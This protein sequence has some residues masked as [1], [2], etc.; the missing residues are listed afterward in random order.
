M[1]PPAGPP[2]G[3]PPGSPAASSNNAKWIVVG[4]LAAAAVAIAAFL[5]LRSDDKKNSIAATSSSSPSS[6]STSSSSSSSSK[7]SSSSSTSSSSGPTAA[8]LQRKLLTAEEVSS[9]LQAATFSPDHTTPSPC[10][11]Q[12]TGAKFPPVIDVGSSA[13]SAD[14]TVF[15]E[16]EVTTYKDAATAAQ[17][18]DFGKQGVSCTQGTIKDGS[19]VT[20]SDPY[21]VSSDVG[22]AG[23]I[24]VDAEAA[25]FSSQIIAV[26]IGNAI[27]SFQFNAASSVDPSNLPDAL[28]IA[29]D[30]LQK[31]GL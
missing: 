26:R 31:L 24:E 8:D 2:P 18:F 10:G 1:A 30:G 3:S 21:D 9:D 4:V 7:S 23:A 15:F 27:V 22:A 20:F 19:A 25:S 29:T 28:T 6:S 16:E 14:S 13:Q 11:Q 5:L 12:S 17:A